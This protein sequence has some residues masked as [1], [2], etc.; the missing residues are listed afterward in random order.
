MEFQQATDFRV[1]AL[2]V[3]GTDIRS[4]FFS[5]ELYE[6]IYIQAVTGTIIVVDTSS[7]QLLSKKRLEGNEE[8]EFEA[9]TVKGKV[10][11][12]GFI[13]RI[14]DKMMDGTAMRFTP[15]RWHSV[16][17]ATREHFVLTTSVQR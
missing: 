13:N 10:Q 12:K 3:D 4:M 11:F 5:A 1:G 9:E 8:I 2:T 15:L 7:N 16:V 6:N 14:A 17:R